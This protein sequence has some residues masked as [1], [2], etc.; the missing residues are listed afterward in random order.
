MLT[1]IHETA[2][3]PFLAVRILQQL[4]SDERVHFPQAL[5]VVKDFLCR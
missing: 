2:S 4:T 3:A 5:K 1:V